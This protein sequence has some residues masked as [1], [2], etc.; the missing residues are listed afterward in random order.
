MPTT[1]LTDWLDIFSAWEAPGRCFGRARDSHGLLRSNLG[2]IGLELGAH[3]LRWAQLERRGTEFAIARRWSTEWSELD[4]PPADLSTTNLREICP[5]LAP[6]RKL[7]R[8]KALAFCL[9]TGGWEWRNLE[10]PTADERELRQMAHQ[11]LAAEM[12]LDPEEIASDYWRVEEGDKSL[13]DGITPVLAVGVAT[14][15]ST[16][17]AN[18]CLAAGFLP[19][20]C[21]VA[22]WALARSVL[23]AQPRLCGAYAVLHIGERDTSIIL[24]RAGKPLYIRQVRQIGY[25]QLLAPICEAWQ[26]STS[27]AA[28]ILKKAGLAGDS[29]RGGGNV[30]ALLNQLLARV[31]GELCGELDRTWAYVGRVYPKLLPETMWLTGS[32]GEI[33]GLDGVLQQKFEIVTQP[34]SLQPL[35]SVWSAGADAPYAMAAGLSALAWE[36]PA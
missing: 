7:F 15:F 27:E 17:I 6:T 31:C 30:S 26:I 33:P 24:C 1:L 28:A 35:I 22:P 21:E 32:G 2:W 5:E 29:H 36:E 18:D 23:L 11:E 12:Q 4:A 14:D 34:W 20:V 3:G 16:R 13:R 8:G 25:M 19:Q 10:L 9:P